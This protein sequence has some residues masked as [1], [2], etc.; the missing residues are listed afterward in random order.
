MLRSADNRL[1]RTGLTWLVIVVSLALLT[2]WGIAHRQTL[3]PKFALVVI[4][5][6]TLSGA[7][8]LVNGVITLFSRRGGWREAALPFCFAISC[9]LLAVTFLW[10]VTSPAAQH[11]TLAGAALFMLSAAV[12]QHRAR[13]RSDSL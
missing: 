2:P 1:I 6:G 9:L 4:V 11:I 8:F 7:A 12:L 13:E 10:D 5:F 3:Q